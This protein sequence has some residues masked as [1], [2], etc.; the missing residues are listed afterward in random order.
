MR[1][2]II[3]IFIFIIVSLILISIISIPRKV[4]PEELEFYVQQEMNNIRDSSE[5]YNLDTESE[6]MLEDAIRNSFEDS[7]SVP[8]RFIISLIAYCIAVVIA[9]VLG[10]VYWAYDRRKKYWHSRHRWRSKW[11]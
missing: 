1:R 7:H 5:N 9:I 4:D 10:I 3:K 11:K 2:I 6:K 8:S